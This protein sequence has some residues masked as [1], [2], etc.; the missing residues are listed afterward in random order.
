MSE[1]YVFIIWNKALFCKKKI[2]SDLK[3]SFHIENVFYIE[4][5]RTS[6]PDNLKAFYGTK[7]TDI[8]KKMDYIAVLEK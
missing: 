4:W 3:K 1:K 8:R 2:L 5:N 7:T 6:Y